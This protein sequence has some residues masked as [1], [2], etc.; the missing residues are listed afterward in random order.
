MKGDLILVEIS[1]QERKM[2]SE[3]YSL[4]K[5]FGNNFIEKIP[6]EIF[7]RIEKARLET[8]CPKY[9]METSF[10]KQLISRDALTIIAFFHV[11]YWCENDEEKKKI[12]NIIQENENNSFNSIF[13]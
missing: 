13:K 3:V 7:E 12:L 1:L 5:L 8:Y 9:N 6:K 11:S 2:Y 10:G 4:L